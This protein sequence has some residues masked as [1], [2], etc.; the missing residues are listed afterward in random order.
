MKLKTYF[1]TLADSTPFT[2]ME[3]PIHWENDQLY[4]DKYAVGRVVHT[5]AGE[6][7]GW[8]ADPFWSE[9]PQFFDLQ[10]E[11]QAWLVAV[12]QMGE[13]KCRIQKVKSK[14]N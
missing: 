13:H 14:T 1:G 5:L 12:Y 2:D 3:L 10:E 8:M 9:D 7:L 6:Q 4:D 11:A